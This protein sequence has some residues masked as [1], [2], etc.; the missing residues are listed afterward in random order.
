M[1]V[2]MKSSTKGNL[3]FTIFS[4]LMDNVVLSNASST[5]L[6]GLS[7]SSK[8]SDEICS[9]DPLITACMFLIFIFFFKEQCYLR[10]FEGNTV[11]AHF[12]R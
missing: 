3:P 6:T 1:T 10:I 2:T 7:E 8:I 5:S 12:S 11:N 4:R 9:R